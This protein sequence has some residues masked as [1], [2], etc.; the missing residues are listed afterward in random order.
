MLCNVTFSELFFFLFFYIDS[1]RPP[2]GRIAQQN[3]GGA[4]VS[5]C[6]PKKKVVASRLK[7]RGASLCSDWATDRAVCGPRVRCSAPRRCLRQSRAS[8]LRPRAAPSF[9]ASGRRSLLAALTVAISGCICDD[10]QRFRRGV[11]TSTKFLS[12]SRKCF[13]AA[14][15]PLCD[16]RVSIVLSLV[17]VCVC[18][19]A[20]RGSLS[21]GSAFGEIQ[22]LDLHRASH[23]EEASGRLRDFCTESE[24]TLDTHTRKNANAHRMFFTRLVW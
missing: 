15:A 10:L 6:R 1:V 16:E 4:S 22:R 12:R 23:A 19:C 5:C 18:V 2:R 7:T 13:S 14:T 8:G 24:V 3:G 20:T 11:F 17:C 9:A 21:P